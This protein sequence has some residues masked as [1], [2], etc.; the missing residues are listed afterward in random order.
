MA[1]LLDVLFKL[2]IAPVIVAKLP[3]VLEVFWAKISQSVL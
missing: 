1:H 3:F 2:D